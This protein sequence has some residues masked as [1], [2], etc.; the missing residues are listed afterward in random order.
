VKDPLRS[1]FK[2]IFGDEIADHR[3]ELHLYFPDDSTGNEFDELLRQAEEGLDFTTDPAFQRVK[4]AL[5]ANSKKH[6]IKDLLKDKDGGSTFID[7]GGSILEVKAG[8]SIREILDKTLAK[9]G[10]LMKN[11]GW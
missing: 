11:V 7:G 5:R 9:R 2:A 6:N 3:G 4:R 10:C 1:I 8:E